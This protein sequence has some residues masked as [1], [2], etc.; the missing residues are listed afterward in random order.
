MRLKMILSAL[1]FAGVLFF[2]QAG[3]AQSALPAGFPPGSL[4]LSKTNPV[5]GESITLFTVLYNASGSSIRGTITFLADGKSIV[6]KEFSLEAGTTKIESTSWK[7]AEGKHSFSALIEGATNPGANEI[8]S[9]ANAKAAALSVSVSPPPPPPPPSPIAEN[10]AIIEEFASSVASSSLP[11][12]ETIFDTTESLRKQGA[13][14]FDNKLAKNAKEKA[15]EAEASSAPEGTGGL[16]AAFSAPAL[17]SYVERAAHYFYT[18]MA[19]LFRTAI[20][21]YPVFV[22]SFL[23]LLRRIYRHL[24]PQA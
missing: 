22:V 19:T 23:W 3:Q 17:A 11:V 2:P 4:W 24:S 7:A 9:V 20:L 10:A 1:L 16:A 8:V 14:Y 13:A 6:T 5:E 12:A 15:S 21:F 18:I